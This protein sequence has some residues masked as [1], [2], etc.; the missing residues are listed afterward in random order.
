MPCLLQIAAPQQ[1]SSPQ[2]G[3]FLPDSL[4]HW[5]VQVCICDP[6]T[7]RSL[8]STLSARAPTQRQLVNAQR[9]QGIDPLVKE[10]TQVQSLPDPIFQ[11]PAWPQAH[12]E[13]AAAASEYG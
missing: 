11:P 4:L 7:Q 9:L 12:F 5:P 2:T 8:L 1:G 3:I 13:T 10:A 6:P